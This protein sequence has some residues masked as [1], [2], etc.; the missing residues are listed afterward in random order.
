[1]RSHGGGELKKRGG[2][3]AW[4]QAVLECLLCPQPPTVPKLYVKASYV[5]LTSAN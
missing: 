1:M 3:V 4:G 5:L 2:G